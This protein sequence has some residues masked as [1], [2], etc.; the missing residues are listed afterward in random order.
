MFIVISISPP[1]PAA[2]GNSSRAVAAASS[3]KRCAT[4]T[5]ARRRAGLV[6][7]AM[8]SSRLAQE[9]GVSN[10]DHSRSIDAET[11]STPAGSEAKRARNSA[12]RRSWQCWIAAVTSSSL[13]G[14]W[15]SCAP[16][17]TPARF[18]TSTVV[19]PA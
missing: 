10:I 9:S 3:L 15:C 6:R 5:S 8:N 17:D 19:V 18:E 7:A 4:G 11:R 13:L 12:M 1:S 2:S 16:R 14:K